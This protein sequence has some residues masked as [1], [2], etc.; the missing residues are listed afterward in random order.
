MDI[1]FIGVDGSGKTTHAKALHRWLYSRGIDSVY[2]HF[3]FSL[4]KYIP[5]RVRKTLYNFSH[6][7]EVKSAGNNVMKMYALLFLVFSLVDGLIY[8]MRNLRSK[9][10]IYDRYFYDYLVEFFELYPNYIK[11]VY[12]SLL[13]RPDIV[14]YLDI[15]PSIAYARKREYS[16][17]FYSLQRER[18]FQLLR[19]IKSQIIIVINTSYSKLDNFSTLLNHILH[20]FYNARLKE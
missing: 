2:I 1:C 10:R 18:Y 14:F 4:R 8:Y 16:L 20:Y 5:S 11:R 6:K 7:N 13:P 3:N 9:I 15:P 12:I 19:Y 17:N